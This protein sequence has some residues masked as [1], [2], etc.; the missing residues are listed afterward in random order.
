MKLYLVSQD[1]H[2]DYDT[3]DSF[4]VACKN[5]DEA[6]NTHPDNRQKYDGKDWYIERGG[7]KFYYGIQEWCVPSK[8]KVKYL[9]EADNGVV[10]VILASFNAG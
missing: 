4:V 9:G 10:G 7:Q 8:V 3:Y 1:V 5:E 2:D 6:R